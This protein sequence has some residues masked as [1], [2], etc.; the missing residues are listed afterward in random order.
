MF[1]GMKI[2]LLGILTVAFTVFTSNG[3]RAQDAATQHLIDQI[4]GEIQ[5]IQQAQAEQAKEIAD[6]EKQIGDL[7]DKLNQPSGNNYASADDLKKLAGQVQ[8]LAKKQQDDNDQILK[9]LEKLGHG[10]TPPPAAGP[11]PQGPGTPGPIG[12]QKGYYYT[13]AQGDTPS[14]IAKA[15][16]DSDK[17]VKVTADQI[18]KANPGL[19]P[20]NLQIGKKIFIPDPNAP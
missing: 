1:G 3:A 14:A 10:T 2:I 6:L 20:K 17:H 7:G 5:D 19:D 9:A 18:L 16:R 15:Y 8:D 13:I 11:S 12:Q 4:N